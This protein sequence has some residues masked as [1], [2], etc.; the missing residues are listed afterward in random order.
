MMIQT[1]HIFVFCIVQLC[2]CF[3]SVVVAVV[4]ILGWLRSGFGSWDRSR[5][6]DSESLNHLNR[7]R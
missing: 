5:S 1:T 6:G 3:F 4:V 2:F 7:S